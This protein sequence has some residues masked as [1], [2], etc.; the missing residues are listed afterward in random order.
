VK[1]ATFFPVASLIGLGLLLTANRASAATCIWNGATNTLWSTGNNWSG[2]GCVHRVP[3]NGDRLAFPANAA[4]F[5]SENDIAGLQ[6]ASVVIYSPRFIIKGTGITVQSGGSVQFLGSFYSNDV[7][8]AFLVLPITLAG[9]L[10]I[11]NASPDHTQLTLGGFHLNGFA[12]TFD[13]S[14]NTLNE[15]GIISGDG[16]V[17]KAGAGAL[18]LES[19]ASFT[20]QLSVNAGF[21]D[22]RTAHALG[23]AGVGNETLLA[24]GTVLTFSRT[25]PA[26]TVDE[27]IAFTGENASL[28]AEGSVATEVHATFTGHIT[29]PSDPAES[30]TLQPDGP[31]DQMLMTGPVVGGAFNVIG[32]GILA[33]AN[34]GDGWS[35]LSIDTTTV[36]VAAAGALPV[37]DVFMTNGTL[38]LH[39]FNASIGLLATDGGLVSLGAGNLTVT[40]PAP[41]MMVV[42]SGITGSGTLTKAGGGTLKLSSA[43]NV[44]F[45]GS[46]VVSAGTLVLADIAGANS[47]AGPITVNGGTLD[48]TLD[49]QI[50]DLSA[51]TINSPG[52]WQLDGHVDTIGSL[53]GDGSVAL[54][55]G[56]LITGGNNA[57]TTFSGVISGAAEVQVYA[58]QKVGTGTLTLSGQNTYTGVTLVL[59]GTLAVDGSLA[60][61]GNVTLD[62]GTTLTGIGSFGNLDAQ[63]ALISPGHSPGILHAASPSLS[64]GVRF[65]VELNGLAPG[66]GYDQLD[67]SGNVILAATNGPSLNVIRRFGPPAG[68]QFTII[69]VAAGHTVSGT[70]NGLPEGATLDLN[71][72]HFSITYKGGDGNDVVLMALEP[73]P[74]VTYYLSEGAT[75][76][77]FDE[78]VL[79]ANPNATAAPVTLTFSKEDGSQV[80]STQTIPAQARAT[81]HVD[82]I[83]GLEATAAS[84]QVRS[85]QGLPLVVERSMFWDASYYAGHTGSA[86]DQPATDWFFAE[87]SQGFFN[88]FVL[89]INPNATPTD[90]TFTFLREADAPVTKTVTV[91]ASTR[92]TLDAGTVPEIVNRSFG[93]TVHA[94]QP[95]MAER[96][97][98]F[99][100]TPTRLWSGGTES[101]GVTALST[102]WFLAEGATGGFFDTFILLSNPNN[103]DAHVTL[104]YLLDTGDTISVP[105]TVPANA[106]LTTNIETEADL[107]LHNAAVSTVVTSDQPIIAERSM[108]WPGAAVPWG[109]GHNSFGVVDAGLHWGL[110][111]GRTGGPLN[112]HTYILL[113]NPQSTAAA[114]TVTF[115]R[116]SGA[117][118]VKTFTVP[119]TSRFNIDTGTIAELQTNP[120]TASFGADIQVTNGVPIIVE[121]SMYWDSNGFQFSG[122]TNATGSRLP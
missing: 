4:G 27:W 89:V 47:L 114:V 94:T 101:A 28:I 85:E 22:A 32:S 40:I 34:A 66:T 16:R 103:A 71:G 18:V 96:S 88:T 51:V 9:P 55:K 69:N 46:T 2:T 43:S 3:Q 65:D 75:G 95:I 118:V 33:L 110:A 67:V 91:G 115:L 48:E 83:A 104:Q 117:P 25:D 102:H 99:G 6:V 13:T 38:D 53:A 77:F 35:T 98:Y 58:L 36:V 76:S 56:S 64:T 7:P 116:E 52:T 81:L 37:C 26:I 39:G 5:T 121:R 63:N 84:T 90:V 10:A 61:A 80:T 92:L 111:E 45:N 60:S 70:F 30:N 119:P 1:R 105:K 108:Y 109:E 31:K 44:I 120:Q 11:A 93:I 20:G 15:V 112:F 14:T 50:G 73:P 17:V 106:R 72:Q 122:G 86:V 113:A 29:G 62:D 78:D 41:K 100:T 49:N 12:L 97:M 19:D 54:A 59:G 79:I 21:V 23:A 82:K 107:R 57:S 24:S 74:A 68:T 42:H 87:G 8:S